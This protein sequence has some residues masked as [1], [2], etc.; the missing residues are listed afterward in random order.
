M[1]GRVHSKLHLIH[2]VAKELSLK[3]IEG[4]FVFAGSE[5]IEVFTELAYNL[6]GSAHLCLSEE[7]KSQLKPF[8]RRIRVLLTKNESLLNRKAALV[9]K[10]LL[11]KLL[12]QITVKCASDLF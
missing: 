3:E 11:A 12:A 1:S 9:D 10:P 8:R 5:L 6:A 4:L 2:A 7:D